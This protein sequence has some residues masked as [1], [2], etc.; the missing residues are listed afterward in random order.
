MNPWKFRPGDRVRL[1]A[2]GEILTVE[3]IA[4]SLDRPRL[5]CIDN[6]PDSD[7]RICAPADLELVTAEPP[8]DVAAA[9][10]LVEL[11]RD[12]EFIGERDLAA[13]ARAIMAQLGYEAAAVDQLH[14]DVVVEAAARLKAVTR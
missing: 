3:K 5:A 9:A 11:A 14:A 13:R 2:T 12:L 4:G 1:R 8:V 10:G 7:W 6:R